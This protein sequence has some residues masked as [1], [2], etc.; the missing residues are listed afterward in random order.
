MVKNKPLELRT[1]YS[2]IYLIELKKPF[3]RSNPN[4]IMRP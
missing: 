3:H 2:Q 4:G 1:S